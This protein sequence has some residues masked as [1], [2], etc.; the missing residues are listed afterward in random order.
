MIKIYMIKS[1]EFWDDNRFESLNKDERGVYKMLDTLK[2]VPKFKRLYSLVATLGSGY[3]QMG[4]FDYGPIFSSFG[5]NDVEGIRLRTG[6]RTYFGQNDPWRIEGYTAY[7][8]KDNKFKYGISGK[9]MVN[10]E[11][12]LFC[13]R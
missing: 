3:Y 11:K 9:W 5:Y 10:K 13:R 8:F 12:E 7:G 2:T 1:D 4:H 6:G